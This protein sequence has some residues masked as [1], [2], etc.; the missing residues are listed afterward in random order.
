[1][2]DNKTPCSNYEVDLAAGLTTELGNFL[3]FAGPSVKVKSLLFS[4][5]NGVNG[6]RI[7]YGPTDRIG[8]PLQDG[9][10][11]NYDR[12][13]DCGIQVSSGAVAGIMLVQLWYDECGVSATDSL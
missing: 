3:P 12:A 9:T 10:A 1:M 6:T 4:F 5:P 7:H 11:F 2:A 13:I 8:F